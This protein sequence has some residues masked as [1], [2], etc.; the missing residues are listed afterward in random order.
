MQ[1]NN[2]LRNIWQSAQ[3]ILKKYNTTSAELYRII[4]QTVKI[5]IYLFVD[6]EIQRDCI[7]RIEGI[8]IKNY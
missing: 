8:N 3:I 5:V 7:P 4:I 1:Q 6:L 2:I